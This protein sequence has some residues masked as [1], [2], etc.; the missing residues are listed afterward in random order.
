MITYESM[1][2]TDHKAFIVIKIGGSILT[3]IPE[4]FYQEL[5]GM[6]KKGWMPVIVHGGGP[7]ITKMLTKLGITSSFV[8]G[9]RVT[10]QET[11]EVVQMVLNGKENKEIVKRI[12]AAGGTAIGLS[13]IDGGMIEAELLDPS[14]G[15]VGKVTNVRFP[16]A[17]LQMSNVIP[18][19]SPLGMDAQ[20]QIYNINADMVAQAI[21]TKL[22]ASKV[23]MVSDIPGIYQEI[24]GKKTILPHLNAEEIG[25][26]IE[27]KQ[28]TGGMIPKVDAAIQCIK[29][30]IKQVYIIDGK[31][32]GILEK[33]IQGQAA[34]TKIEK[35][36]VVI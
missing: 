31:E 11:L 3:E 26:L 9:L 22:Q 25:T 24:D 2:P 21:A 12:Q 4:L 1:P 6:T 15:F 7:S 13:G 5:V 17:L 34:G 33:I 28:L 18:V 16:M 14:L 23:I 32:E 30:G 35:K 10:D 29:Q 19:I 20:G 8:Q 27:A 36:A